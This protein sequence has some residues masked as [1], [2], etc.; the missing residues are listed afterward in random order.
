QF[1]EVDL[2]GDG[3]LDLFVFDRKGN[4]MATYL[5]GGTANQM[6]YTYAPVFTENFPNLTEWALLRDYNGDGAMDIFAASSVPGIPGIEVYRGAYENGKLAFE[7]VQFFGIGHDVLLFN[8][9]TGG[10]SNIYVSKQ[11]IPAIDD[12]DGD[13]DLDVLSF[14]V[15][16]GYIFH[17]DN[18]S[19]ELGYGSDSLIF[20]L[21]TS[22]LGG[23]YESGISGCICL[24]ESPGACCTALNGGGGDTRH[25]GSTLVTF[26]QDGDG[27]LELVLGDLS[28]TNMVTLFNMGNNEDVFYG[29]QD[30]NFPVDDVPIDLDVFP[31]GFYLDIDNDGRKDFLATPN[32]PSNTE[33]YFCVWHY[34]N[35]G[36][37]SNPDLKLR[38]KNLFVEDMLDMGSGSHPTFVDYNQD[39][40]LD[41]VIGTETFYQPFGE[42]DPRLFLYENIGT[43]TAPAFRLINED[44]LNFSQY[45]S[46]FHTLAPTF[47]DLDNDGDLDLM[48]GGH[49]GK[50]FYFENIAGA[51]N[52]FNF[53]NPQ[54]EY[55]DIDVGRS[56]T[57]QIVDVDRDGLPDLLIGEGNG[58]LNFIKNIGTTNE[59]DFEP[60][61][62]D[63]PNDEFF[64]EV[65]TSPIGLPFGSSAPVLVDFDGEYTLFC[66]SEVRGVFLY[67]DID[68]N[69]DASF[70]LVDE[71]YGDNVRVGN[72]VVPA[73]ADINND[74][75]LDM[76]VGNARGGLNFFQTSFTVSGA[77]STQHL[78]PT[79]GFQLFPNPA[80]DQLSIVLDQVQNR[81]VE[82]NIYNAFGQL[83][84][85]NLST[86]QTTNL[87][88]QDL[89]AGL[90]LCELRIGSQF[91]VRKFIVQ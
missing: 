55:L 5:N 8:N 64:G 74:N 69:L 21:K 54:L 83:L 57:P 15:N 42:D 63:A 27:D 76:V 46:N 34:E 30:C 14:G 82:I 75:I 73:F 72:F 23:I 67:T 32:A 85:Q 88:I 48:V 35:E 86:D 33:N 16:G 90:Y 20:D 2:D 66:G 62:E 22:C 9:P 70:T 31:A 53:A 26:D 24:P 81:T 19:Q 71:F 43:P 87:D 49:T 41:I 79:A 18:R 36:S 51:G 29:S 77:L 68:E 44:Y 60:K 13:G 58:N 78:S 6:D 91:E 47:G 89:S 84:Q 39:G 37:T 28:F 80:R 40:L 3:T 56:S 59:P 10:V 45:G 17:Y 52:P 1:S 61:P 38:K 65:D 25:A 7:Q 11:D 12:I 50:L 4:A